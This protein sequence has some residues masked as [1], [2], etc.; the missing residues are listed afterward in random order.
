MRQL[1]VLRET[2]V[3]ILFLTLVT[4]LNWETIN[5][6]QCSYAFLKYL[7]VV[8]IIAFIKNILENTV[9]YHKQF[10]FEVA[11]ST[12]HAI[13]QLDD[14]IFEFF[15]NN[16]YCWACLL[17]FPKASWKIRSHDVNTAMF[18]VT[19]FGS[20]YFFVKPFLWFSLNTFRLN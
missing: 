20:K 18:G 17:T 7:N 6:Y 10:G 15:E 13:V 11:Y 16:L 19:A 14:Q 1:N 5:Q 2:F 4:L 8:C 9:L 12:D 3:L